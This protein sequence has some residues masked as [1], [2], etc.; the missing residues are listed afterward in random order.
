M[1]D[2]WKRT[3]LPM[4]LLLC[5]I[6]GGASNGGFFENAILQVVA[7]AMACTV[8]AISP[9][10]GGPH[11]DWAFP[12]LVLGVI[13]VVALQFL[14][15][16]LSLWKLLPGRG[17]IAAELGLISVI[18]EWTF[19]TLS[20]HD[21]LASLAWFLPA[22]S[23][24]AVL[25]VRREVEIWAL[26]IVIVATAFFA[27][28]LGLVQF[29]SGP[30]S[31][32]Y[33]YRFTNRGLMVGFFSNAN[34]MATFLLV[35]L[36]FLAAVIRHSILERPRQRRE[37]MLLGA[38]AGGFIF[39]GV[40]LVGSL[41]G[42]AL[43]IPV[44]ALSCGILIPYRKKL[45]VIGALPLLLFGLGLVALTDEG[46]NVFS[47][48]SAGAERG[49]QQIFSTTIE[50]ASDFFPVGSGLGT[51]RDVYDNYEDLDAVANV[52]VNHAHSDY[53]EIL[54]EFGLLGVVAIVAFL[55]WW[56]SRIRVVMTV[57]TEVPFL[58]ASAI[59]SGTI[60]AHSIWDYPLRTTALSTTFALCC[61]MLAR[62]GRGAPRDPRGA[63][64]AR[65][66][67]RH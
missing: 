13:F 48:E 29:L 11:T 37:L 3:Y 49:R 41:T 54:L 30:E 16:P 10:S 64:E 67:A 2:A 53:L 44:L 51:F 65:P 40:V 26:A 6:F 55:V 60:L 4:F 28:G 5:L 57:G 66:D 39:L 43:A 38:V 50:A 58:Y 9:A 62:A 20:I 63:Q 7:V 21:S 17:E 31:A 1:I 15:L 33:F 8:L 23:M 36:P 14:P 34:H 52:Y 27:I 19:V 12:W 18:P 22:I 25:Y 46:A 61:L 35:A 42:Y 56:A 47:E 59:A 32:A 45:V 24:A